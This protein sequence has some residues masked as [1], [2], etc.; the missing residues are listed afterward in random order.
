MRRSAVAGFALLLI[1]FFGLVLVLRVVVRAADTSQLRDRHAEA[2]E[3]LTE[4]AAELSASGET[5]AAAKLIDESEQRAGW[6]ADFDDELHR[7]WTAVALVGTG[8]LGFAAGG[9]ALLRKRRRDLYADVITT[10]PPRQPTPSTMFIS[11]ARVDREAVE[12][13]HAGLVE[14]HRDVWVDWTGIPPTAEWMAEIRR[15]IDAADA[16]LFALSPASLRSTVCQEELRYAFDAGKRVIPVV[17]ADVKGVPMPDELARINWIHPSPAAVDA[18]ETA[19]DLDLDR[20]HLHTRLLVRAREWE[21]AGRE[22]GYLLAGADLQRARSAVDDPALTA[23][24]L[25]YVATSER[26]EAVRG[27]REKRGVYLASLGFGALFPV[28]VYTVAFDEIT[29]R[30][31]V[32][33]APVWVLA[34]IFGVTGLAA[35]RA[36]WRRPL[37]AAVAGLALLATFFASVFP[38]L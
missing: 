32:R 8:A 3:L 18:I 36:T 5:T 28:V 20:V 34:L 30:G 22:P 11:Y 19:A 38:L 12:P 35:R 33:L 31:L 23:L 4:Q 17:V 7:Q 6:A 10:A 2:A 25:T 27:R 1:A 29:E 26:Y 24:Q 14:R 37:V 15:A 13:L 16:V 9:A 21:T